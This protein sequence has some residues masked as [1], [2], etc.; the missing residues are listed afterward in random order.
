M[1]NYQVIGKNALFSERVLPTPPN[2]TA[3]L[4]KNLGTNFYLPVLY[5]L[6]HFAKD[7]MYVVYYSGKNCELNINECDVRKRIG[8]SGKWIPDTDTDTEA[9]EEEGPCLNGAICIDGIN[10]FS[11]QCVPGY[12]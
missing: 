6:V 2:K 8:A 9:A 5:R 7:I 12:T 10:D 1:E 4:F 11:C 3:T